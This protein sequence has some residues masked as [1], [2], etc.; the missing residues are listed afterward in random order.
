[1]LLACLVLL[2]LSTA[3]GNSATIR[4]MLAEE[5]ECIDG[6]TEEQKDNGDC[7]PTNP[8]SAAPK[9]YPPEPVLACLWFRPVWLTAIS[10][11]LHP[12]LS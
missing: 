7:L 2:C 11:S 9:H 12:S 1:M 3:W 4:R 5:V 10:K 8:K 6:G